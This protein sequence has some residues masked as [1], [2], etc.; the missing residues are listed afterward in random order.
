MYRGNV[1][2]QAKNI[3][4]IKGLKKRNIATNIHEESMLLMTTI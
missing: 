3:T 4:N 2:A 1:L